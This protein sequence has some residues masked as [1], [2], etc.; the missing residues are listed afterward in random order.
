M[1]PKQIITTV[2][3][4]LIIVACAA[5]IYKRWRDLNPRATRPQPGQPPPAMMP[6]PEAPAPSGG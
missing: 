2:V 1:S 5:Y 4:I 3:C 6:A